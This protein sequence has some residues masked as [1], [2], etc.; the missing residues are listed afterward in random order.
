MSEIKVAVIIPD[1]GDRPLFLKNCS[2]M[3]G[4]QT[5]QPDQ[6]IHVNYKPLTQSFDLVNRIRL[7]Y[8]E[9]NDDIDV[10]AIMENDDWYSQDYLSVMC[11]EWDKAGRPDIFGI[12]NKIYYHIK[13]RKYQHWDTRHP[14]LMNTLIKNNL[15]LTFPRE[16]TTGVDTHLWT[17]LKGKTFNPKK[18]LSLGIK[19]G[20]GLCGGRGHNLSFGYKKDDINLTYLKSI[21]DRQSLDFYSRFKIA[22]PYVTILINTFNERKEWLKQTINSYLNNKAVRKQIIVCT[23]PTDANLQYLK[24]V[25]EIELHLCNVKDHPGKSPQGTFY[26]INSVIKSHDLKGDWFCFMSSND[27]VNHDRMIKEI[28][29]C[30][31]NKKS[32]CYSAFDE[33]QEE[34]NHRKT[35]Y[36]F[37]YEFKKHLKGN[38]V[39][40]AALIKTNL[41]KQYA[42][43]KYLELGNYS[44]WDFWLRIY[45]G[46]GNVFHYYSESTWS[47]RL[48]NDSMHLQ[49]RTD[50]Q[51]QQQ[52]R[53]WYNKMLDYNNRRA[54]L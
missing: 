38:F 20:E 53:V 36:F 5:K 48:N 14:P 39:S 31:V 54:L 18:I 19:H 8:S 52:G 12:Q 21:V 11:S 10:V 2:R 44:Y 27:Y 47:Y 4:M 15:T 28:E 51:A 7:G 6:I 32:I 25:P 35:R 41:L 49:R 3:V 24:T 33:F 43:F 9:V 23:L 1:R 40:D 37:P 42:P 22:M 30:I 29:Q 16:G 26:Q 45:E 46:E 17:E 50:T 13:E 34:I